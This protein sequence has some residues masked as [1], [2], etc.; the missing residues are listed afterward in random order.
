MVV[1]IDIE[2]DGNIYGI[3]SMISFGAVIVDKE[4]KLNKT[5]YGQLKPVGE[6]WIPEALE[7]S[8]HSREDTLKFENPEIVMKRFNEWI[9]DNL[10]S[11]KD[12]P[13]FYSDNNGFD[14]GWINY[15]FLKF[16]GNN[17][18]GH[19]STNIGS[20]YKGLVKDMFQN[21]KHLK[22]TKHTHHPVDDAKGNAESL[23]SMK[24]LGLSIRF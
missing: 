8:G 5:F 23:I 10:Q 22:I 7:V 13:H 14:Y 24:N 3:H 20:L 21:F 2:A 19:S 9:Q 4:E 6:E 18:F 17:P 16:T 12:R 15:Y 1:V 11:K